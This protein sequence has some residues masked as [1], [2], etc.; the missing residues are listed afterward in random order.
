M[1]RISKG[2]DKKATWSY[3]STRNRE[4]KTCS[5]QS[6]VPS[7]IYVH[8]YQSINSHLVPP[9]AVLSDEIDDTFFKPK[10]YHVKI[11]RAYTYYI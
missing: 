11:F 9:T 8:I 10:K 6:R 5:V 4:K 2:A 1:L 3:L 7:V